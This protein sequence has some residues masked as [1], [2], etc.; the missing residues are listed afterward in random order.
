MKLRVP[1]K[2]HKVE[3]PKNRKRTKEFN[4]LEFC[5]KCHARLLHFS[6]LEKVSDY[7]YCAIC[8]DVA[9]DYD[10]SVLFKLV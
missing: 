5:P 4:P 9:Y 8:E 2:P 1:M 10:G 6:G 7:F 3:T